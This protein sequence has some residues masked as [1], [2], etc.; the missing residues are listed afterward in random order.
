MQLNAH[1][2]SSRTKAVLAVIKLTHAIFLAALL[3]LL[4][5]FAASTFGVGGKA[6]R[7]V[8]PTTITVIICAAV[9][10]V[11]LRFAL[12]LSKRGDRG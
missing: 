7:T 8:F 3:V 1:P 10:M 2:S 6:V 5:C 9:A 4:L 11:L 12:N